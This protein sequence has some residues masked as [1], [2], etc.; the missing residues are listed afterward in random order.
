MELNRRQRANPNDRIPL[1]LR[2]IRDIEGRELTDQEI[3]SLSERYLTES[4]S[5]RDSREEVAPLSDE[6]IL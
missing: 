4:Q 3:R 2:E 1:T 6:I 5:N